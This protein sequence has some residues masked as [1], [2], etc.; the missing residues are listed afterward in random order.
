MTNEYFG[1][2]PE[3]NLTKKQLAAGD[4]GEKLLRIL[5]LACFEAVVVR[6]RSAG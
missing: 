1:K 5:K 4:L 2:I 6:G 3:L